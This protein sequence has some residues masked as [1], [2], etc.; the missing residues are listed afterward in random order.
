[1]RLLRLGFIECRIV[2][3][4][5]LLG[6]PAMGADD[7][8]PAVDTHI[9]RYSPQT[10]VSGQI[11]ITGSSTM[12]AILE[13]WKDKL[14]TVHPGLYIRLETKGSNE[15]VE[16]LISGK[17]PIAAM[18]RSMR[19]E[20]IKSFTK[21]MGYPPVAVPVAVEAFA[22]FVHKDN[23][24]DHVTFQ[25]LDAIFSA[26]RRRGNP[27]SLDR[28]GQLGLSGS[29]EPAPIRVQVRDGY[30][31]TAQFFRE[32]VLLGGEEKGAVIVQP[33]AA[34]VVYAVMNDPYAIGY[35]G[36]GYRTNSVKPLHVAAFE[37]EP[38]VEPTFESAIN[39]TYPL[40]RVL[41]LYVN[42]S[43]HA[44]RSPVLSEIVS[45]ALSREGQE[46]VARAGFFSLP[47]KDLLAS[48]TAWSRPVTS[49]ATQKRPQGK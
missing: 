5:T 40:R 48:F 25:Q 26:E 2:V 29:W 46:V 19:T 4:L 41:Y 1:M 37:G 39:G 44:E 45:F 24:L 18:S 15:G 12:Q 47:A 20:E 35:S 33:G 10:R 17:T 6:P 49:A 36:I 14:E 22:V 8:F 16:A 32:L 11:D 3:A 31:G 9:P 28:W 21:R 23:P 34:S 7:V 38:F 43:P 42:Q 30:S 13:K 27:E